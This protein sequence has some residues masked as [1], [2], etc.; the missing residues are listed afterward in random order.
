MAAPTC[1]TEAARTIGMT[2]ATL[3]GVLV[4]T[5]AKPC[6]VRFLYRCSKT[7]VLYTTPWQSGGADGSPFSAV[8]N[9]A[10]TCHSYRYLAQVAN[11]DGHGEG[12]MLHHRSPSKPPAPDRS[13][14]LVRSA[15]K[16]G[17]FG[18]WTIILTTDVPCHLSL[19]VDDN[20]PCHT[21][22]EHFKRGIAYMHTPLTFFA[23]KW[24][25]VQAER[26]DSITHTFLWH[27]RKPDGKYTLQ[28][29]GTVAGR[30][31][32][33]KS[34]FYYIACKPEPAPPLG[35]NQSSI[36]TTPCQPNSPPQAATPPQPGTSQP[37]LSPPG[38]SIPSPSTPTQTAT[39]GTP[40]SRS[41]TTHV[42]ARQLLPQP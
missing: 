39:N 34:P 32:S 2:Y 28:A 41:S 36:S 13:P 17:P 22:T 18:V 30:L 20:V 6:L 33:R 25:L 26:G 29:T 3:E 10:T 9:V 19:F 5:G 40:P 21:N 15:E 42:R 4:S 35:I 8:I 31:S 24:K 27:C 16:A 38:S 12:R 23:P 14:F 1:T 7:K 37:S 11:D